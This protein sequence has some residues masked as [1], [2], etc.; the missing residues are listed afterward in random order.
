MLIVATFA[1]RV[2]AGATA[3][4]RTSAFTRIGAAPTFLCDQE[5][6][7]FDG[8]ES[9]ARCIANFPG[10]TF[11]AIALGEAAFGRLG[12]LVSIDAHSLGLTE[13]FGLDIFGFGAFSDTVTFS[14]GSMAVFSFDVSGNGGGEIE[15]IHGNFQFTNVPP[16]TVLRFSYQI[17]P[18]VPLA[19]DFSLRSELRGGGCPSFSPCDL[20]EL[21]DLSDTAALEPVQVLDS[22]GNPLSG[23]TITSESGFDYSSAGPVESNAPNPARCCSAPSA[24]R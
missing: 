1:L 23:V 6:Q 10:G 17:T 22:L 7:H 16:T 15:D 3:M 9:R 18:G 2:P 20:H 8:T 21:S 5:D 19:I 24:A 13:G 12:E 11:D 14:A 4:L